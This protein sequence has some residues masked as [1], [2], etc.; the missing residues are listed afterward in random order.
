MLQ[1]GI[2]VG[3]A[4]MEG[5]VPGTRGARRPGRAGGAAWWRT[6]ALHPL[7]P[8][9]LDPRVCLEGGTFQ[10]PPS[11]PPCGAQVDWQHQPAASRGARPGMSWT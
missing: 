1:G 3:R 11:P 2:A 8:G 7:A 6:L 5:E 4:S 9:R 10:C